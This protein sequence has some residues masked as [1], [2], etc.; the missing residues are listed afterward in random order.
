MTH[1]THKTGGIQNTLVYWLAV[2][3]SGLNHI[4]CNRYIDKQSRTY[5][6]MIQ[7]NRS[8]KQNLVEGSLE[9]SIESNLKLTGISR[10]SY[11]ELVEDYRDFLWRRGL[12][13]WDKNDPRVLVIRRRLIN[14]H[15]THVTHES[16]EWNGISFSDPEAL[17][18]LMITLCTKQGFLLDRF[19]KGIQ[20]RFIKEGGFR[21][22]LF[23]KRIQERRKTNS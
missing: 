10:A 12:K 6:Q 23:K 4:F 2:E 5:D 19:L 20:E 18:N 14:P 15:E 11:G 22:N 17:A 21:E 16:H 13:L 9:N 3:I 8:G 1:P 7:A